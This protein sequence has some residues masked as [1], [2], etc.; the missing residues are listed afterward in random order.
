M[1]FKIVTFTY[2][3]AQFFVALI[4]VVLLNGG[5]P[6][7]VFLFIRESGIVFGVKLLAS[8]VIK[9]VHTLSLLITLSI[10][11]IDLLVKKKPAKAGFG[12]L[13]NITCVA[14]QAVDYLDL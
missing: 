5:H 8:N 14:C 6:C 9:I 10:Q 11:Q 1:I 3:D 12:V 7:F 13:H 4:Y 2:K